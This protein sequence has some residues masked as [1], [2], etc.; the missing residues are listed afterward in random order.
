VRR[1]FTLL[2][3]IAS[4]LAAP[5]GAAAHPLGNF[6]INRYSA[7]E[8][9]GDRIY[10]HY[11]LD[12]A[13]I[14][15]LQ[16]GTEASRP[17][18]ARKLARGLELR[19]DA[20][21]AALR[22]L[23]SRARRRPGAG[24]LETL[25]VEAV[26]EAARAGRELSYRDGNFA[27]RRGW[28]EVVVRAEG[29]ARLESSSAPTTSVSRALTAYPQK[30]LREPPD[31]TSATASYRAGSLGGTPPELGSREP[32]ARDESRFESLVSHELSA[33]FVLVSLAL[34][35]FWGAAH[36]LG[37]GHGKAIVAG[38]LVGTRGT[39]RHALLLGLIVT[40]THTIG[41]FALGLVTL[42]LSEF[43]VPEQLYPW[44][45]LVAA[46]LVLAV[47]VGVLRSR[48]AEWL[49]TRAHAREGHDHHRHHHHHGHDHRHPEPGAGL[50]G[51]VGVGISGGIVPCP[52]AL[53]VLLSAISL[54]RVGYGLVLIVAFSL[55]LAASIT[56]IGL[57]AVT[58][59]RLF[60][61]VSLQ[62]PLVRALP[63]VSAVVVLGLGLAM[64]VR[65]LPPLL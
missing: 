6:T 34:A 7:V 49:H 22:L 4:V 42:A 25:R 43:I 3:V 59:K 17:A 26:Y 44:L 11:V 45:N 29:G 12:L 27:E 61:R 63:A 10:V 48:L 38:Y 20:R 53:V 35:L 55:G 9:S 15:T 30:L 21:P 56:A 1:S 37:P 50:R 2:I 36:A 62:G 64:T 41:V 32:A 40:V 19:V 31:T 28:R 65:A 54:H 57:L 51:L 60:S 5:A 46:L 33:G 24:G 58:A 39:P 18:F 47:G 13:E 16:L 8:L 23:G 14:P 52:T